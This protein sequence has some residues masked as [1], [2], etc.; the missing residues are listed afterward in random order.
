MSSLSQFC[1]REQVVF[2][3]VK[4]HDFFWFLRNSW[5]F[6]FCFKK[7]VPLACTVVGTRYISV[8][9]LMET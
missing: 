7:F 4:H 3:A 2:A 5:C 6:K 8:G 1:S 9:P